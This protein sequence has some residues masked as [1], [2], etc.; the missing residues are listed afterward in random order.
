MT[1]GWEEE[2]GGSIKFRMQLRVIEFNGLLK[3]QE[4]MGGSACVG[5]NGLSKYVNWLL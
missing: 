2:A 1:D 4:I 3:L 5:I